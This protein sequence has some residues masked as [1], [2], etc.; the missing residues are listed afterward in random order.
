MM[1]NRKRLC[2]DDVGS[3]KIICL[4]TNK[5]CLL[6]YF[7]LLRTKSLLSLK[8]LSWECLNTCPGTFYFW[9]QGFCPR[10]SNPLSDQSSRAGSRAYWKCEGGKKGHCFRGWYVTLKYDISIQEDGRRDLFP[11]GRDWQ[12]L[13]RFKGFSQGDFHYPKEK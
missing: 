7:V 6:S 11:K 5:N 8:A 12:M 9:G 10:K 13:L 2:L 4:W 3:W 1:E